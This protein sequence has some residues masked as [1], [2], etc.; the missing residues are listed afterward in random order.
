MNPA[1]R[2]GAP[3]RRLAFAATLLAACSAPTRAPEPDPADA[4]AAYHRALVEGRPGEAFGLLHPDAREGLDRAG[5]EALYARQRDAL[6]A[7]AERLLTLARAS[8]PEQ[9]A[10]VVVGDTEA[11]LVLTDEG[12]RLTAPVGARP[13]PDAPAEPP[14]PQ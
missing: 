5:F 7:Q 6:L 13:P 12:W 10:R 9:R 3:L 2:N 11:E 4:V 14:P 8:R 1:I